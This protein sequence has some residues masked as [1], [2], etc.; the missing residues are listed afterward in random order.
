MTGGAE[1][2]AY[3]R[4]SDR[5]TSH[6]A[7]ASVRATELEATVLAELRKYLNGATS[8]QLAESLRLSL[9]TVSPRMRP[10]VSKGLAEDSGR[11]VTGPSGR[12]QTIWR[13][14]RTTGDQQ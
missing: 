1:T 9:V 8:Y 7:A 13:A 3:A 14:V 12:S 11:R 5:D 2:S 6:L 4:A 10:L